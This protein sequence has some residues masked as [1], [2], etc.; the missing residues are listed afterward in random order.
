MAYRSARCIAGATSV[1]LL[2]L[3]GCSRADSGGNINEIIAAGLY[4]DYNIVRVPDG[5]IEV[6]SG[7]S[8]A[9]ENTNYAARR[10]APTYI[11]AFRPWETAGLLTF[12]EHQQSELTA[13]GRMGARTFTVVPS[14]RLRSAADTALATDGYLMIPSARVI[15][16]QIAS[17]AAYQ[18]P[19]L[20]PSEQYRL[21][22]GTYRTVPSD[23]TKEVNKQASEVRF[24]FKALLKFDPIAKRFTYEAADFGPVDDNV[25]STKR[26]P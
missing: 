4:R 17:D 1:I 10:F 6:M 14:D 5:R 24:R 2:V 19:A 23:I 7:L 12:Q 18:S 11:E 8:A 22:F 15:V 9:V 16:E 20:P 3:F 26:V 25:Y 21:V 13:I